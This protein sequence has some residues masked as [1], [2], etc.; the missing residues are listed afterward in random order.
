MGLKV[1][2]NVFWKTAETAHSLYLFNGNSICC[3]FFG[4]Q[5]CKPQP[6][7]QYSYRNRHKHRSLLFKKR[8]Q[9]AASLNHN[10]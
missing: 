3:V 5:S 1:Q 6:E 9:K 7:K 10:L 8:F 2:L 4:S